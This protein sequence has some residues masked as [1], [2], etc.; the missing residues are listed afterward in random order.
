MYITKQAD[1]GGEVRPHQD[2]TFLYT[3][4]QS[5]VGIWWALEDCNENNGCLWAVPGSHKQGVQKWFRRKDSEEGTEFVPSE[6]ESSE[7]STEGAIPLHMQAG[8]AVLLHSAVVH[9]R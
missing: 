1:F 8:D 2:G 6:E 3:N 9:F 5:V 4:P 7:L